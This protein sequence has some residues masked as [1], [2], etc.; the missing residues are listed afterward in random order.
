MSGMGPNTMPIAAPP[1][2]AAIRVPVAP[3]G[4]SPAARSAPAEASAHLAERC[5]QS[6]RPDRL[7]HRETLLPRPDWRA[8]VETLGLDFHSPKGDP[9]AEPY[10]WEAV[11]YAFSAAEVDLI[12]KASEALHWLCLE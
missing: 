5:G 8:K 9:G 4:R 10:W 11:C 1:R 2:H 7:V 3:A 6:A 12:E